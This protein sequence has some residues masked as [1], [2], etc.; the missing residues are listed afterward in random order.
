MNFKTNIINT[1][2]NWNEA[3]DFNT[4][5]S[6]FVN[7]LAKLITTLKSLYHENLKNWQF[8]PNDCRYKEQAIKNS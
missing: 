4:G 8:L 6:R 1:F 3:N 7:N 2:T 5:A